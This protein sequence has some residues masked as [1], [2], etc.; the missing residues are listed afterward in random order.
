MLFS[1]LIKRVA[2][3]M[4]WLFLGS[5]LGISITHYHIFWYV[6]LIALGGCLLVIREL[7]TSVICA[8][9]IVMTLFLVQFHVAWPVSFLPLVQLGLIVLISNFI[10]SIVLT[11][12]YRH[13]KT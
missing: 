10:F 8:V 7:R 4:S 9:L 13:A 3:L 2:P 11:F 5:I 12:V 1:S 6:Y